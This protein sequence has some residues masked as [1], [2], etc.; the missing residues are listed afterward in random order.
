SVDDGHLACVFHHRWARTHGW[1]PVMVN[2]RVG[3]RPPAWL[4]PER[5]PRFNRLRRRL[6]P[7]DLTGI[8]TDNDPDLD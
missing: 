3:W 6:D 7:T 1:E 2:G 4:D 5:A 8:D